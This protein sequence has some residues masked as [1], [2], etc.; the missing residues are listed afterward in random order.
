MATYLQGMQDYIPSVEPFN[1]DYKFLS[2]VLNV[3]QDRYDTNFKQL[4]NLYNQVANS[5]L[6]RED[7]KERRDQYVNRMSN[8]LK[9]VA[10]L[11]LSLGQNVEAAKGLFRPFFEDDLMVKDIAYTKQ[12]G[13][14]MRDVNFYQTSTNE[15]VRD[16]YW[17]EGL[18]KMQMDMEDFV[19]GSPDDALNASLPTYVENPNIYGRA[20]DALKAQGFTASQ[21]T[22][23]G[24]WIITDKNG[25]ALTNRR[26]GRFLTDNQGEY[27]LDENNEK[28]PETTDVLFNYLRETVMKD[29]VIQ[30]GLAVKAYV[31]AR[32][33][34]KD[35]ANI[36][37]YGSE[38][39]AKR[40]W[41]AKYH[42]EQNDKDQIL[43]TSTIS[44]KNATKSIVDRWEQYKKKNKIIPGS[45]EEELMLKKVFELQILDDTQKAVETRI[46]NSAQPTDNIE[47]LLNLGYDA[48]SASII[49]PLLKQA[50][51][52][53]STIGAEREIEM[54][55]LSKMDWE[56]K[57]DSLLQKQ[58]DD[59]MMNRIYA[60]G[61]VQSQLQK[62]KHEY[63]KMLEILKKSLEGGVGDNYDYTP[64]TAGPVD[65]S[66]AGLNDKSTFTSAT[67][68]NLVN[69]NRS[70]AVNSAV[71]IQDEEG[72]LMKLI[73]NSLPGQFAE[74]DMVLNNGQ[75]IQYK[76]KACPTCVEEVKMEP[77]DVALRDLTEEIN[78]Q[79]LN[80]EEYKRLWSSVVG[81]ID[82]IATQAGSEHKGILKWTDIPLLNSKP[83]LEKKIL[84][85]RTR[86]LQMKELYN[87]ITDNKNKAYIELWD[88]ILTNDEAW[89]KKVFEDGYA[90]AVLSPRETEMLRA[91]VPYGMIQQYNKLLAKGIKPKT[92]AEIEAENKR[93]WERY[94]K[95][96][97]QADLI[98]GLDPAFTLNHINNTYGK[99][100]SKIDH[101]T[102]NIPTKGLYAQIMVDYVTL[103][104]KNEEEIIEYINGLGGLTSDDVNVNGKV[105][106]NSIKAWKASDNPNKHMLAA[107]FSQDII[108]DNLRFGNSD[109]AWY[110]SERGSAFAD[111]EMNEVVIETNDIIE[112]ANDYY[113]GESKAQDTDTPSEGKGLIQLLDEKMSSAE[114]VTKGFD[115]NWV[116]QW[117]GQ[118]VITEGFGVGQVVPRTRNFKYDAAAPKQNYY[119]NQQNDI[120]F[121][122][123]L[124]TQ[125]QG[126][127]WVAVLGDEMGG[128]VDSIL[129]GNTSAG[130][131][132]HTDA[133][134]GAI[135]FDALSMDLGSV[136][137]S[138]SVNPGWDITYIPSGSS[139]NTGSPDSSWAAYKIKP[140]VKYGDHEKFDALISLRLNELGVTD[141]AQINKALSKWRSEGITIF[142]NSARDENPL[143]P[144]NTPE[145][146]VASQIKRTGEPYLWGLPNG[147]YLQVNDM[148]NGQYSFMTKTMSFKEDDKG[149]TEDEWIT[150]NRTTDQYGLTDIM[151]SLIDEITNNANAQLEIE[152]QWK[153]DN[154]I[155]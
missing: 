153:I 146:P 87:H 38:D 129:A 132:Y 52:T 155:N 31:D 2:N 5:P 73:L 62:E 83:E 78:G 84:Y 117:T 66:K 114:A 109:K 122:N 151:F 142:H 69:V 90:P 18:L 47:T 13:K 94:E 148:G 95:S 25:T 27:I 100:F 137:H 12:Y 44:E 76:Y 61:S 43:L 49:G 82:A 74:S 53:Y 23:D 143:H 64:P 96:G 150:L 92:A 48:Y 72:V 149:I 89:R 113:D 50:A 126:T 54:N 125:H 36:Q 99:D 88:D 77:F 119:T 79:R 55:P 68:P 58:R 10:G 147:G 57:F 115:F 145:D 56:F 116:A 104:G 80:D 60:T 134:I 16:R 111:H 110:E 29:P 26:T 9:Q 70:G 37:K 105:E 45:A 123:I 107:L 21:T 63:D 106:W 152:K 41:V 35:P 28:I 42:E 3:R 85:H 14:L 33:F 59:A 127:E 40:A 112:Y 6:S 108:R 22:P 120:L 51:S 34:Y 24:D 15:E 139:D 138:A 19:N 103:G 67:A 130:N 86:V 154:N 133:N 101:E 141:K 136:D 118:G 128:S 11:D 124:K 20:F 65:P 75:T 131:E 81:P 17:N 71:E 7:N 144:K 32:T 93:N 39:G 135:L 1:P 121:K 102:R 30:R 97:D 98:V 46:V 4:N 8:G 91:G 140:N